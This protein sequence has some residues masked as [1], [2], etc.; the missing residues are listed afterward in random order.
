[1]AQLSF[2]NKEFKMRKISKT[3]ILP[4]TGLLLIALSG[5]ALSG[6]KKGD[7]EKGYLGVY[8]EDIDRELRE[9]LD[10]KGE[11]VF[12]DDIVDDSPAKEAGIEPGDIVIKFAGKQVQDSDDLRKIIKNT[13]PDTKVKINIIRDGKEKT[14]SAKIGDRKDYIDD[15]VKVF[16]KGFVSP[17]IHIFSDKHGI[18]DLYIKGYKDYWEKRAFLGVN[19]EKLSKGLAEYFEVKFGAMVTEVIEDSPAEKA[20][21]KPGDII[22]E[23]RGREVREPEDVSHYIKKNDVGDKV[24]VKVVRKGKEMTFN[25]ELGE[26]PHGDSDFH[27]DLYDLENDLKIKELELGDLE[28]NL[29]A[30]EENLN[31]MDIQINI[32]DNFYGTTLRIGEKAAD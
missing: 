12:I 4:L 1:M 22:T 24:E 30:L 28:E 25:V 23:Y 14:L 5:I 3:L 18:P 13:K 2:Y 19:M 6:A 17:R 16:G 27:G 15:K 31:D 20:G 10:F 32:P 7:K 11:G 21:L 26:Y 29:H 9:S 8:L